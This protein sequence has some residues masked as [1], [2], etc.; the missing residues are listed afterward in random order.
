MQILTL[1]IDWEITIFKVLG[2]MGLF[3]YGMDLLGKSLKRLA[4]SKLKII[5]EKTTNTPLKGIL[6]GILITGLLQ[7]SS[8]VSV[9]VIGLVRAGLMTLPQ[10]IGVI[11]GANI[12]T[13]IT[14]VLIG[15]DIGK[16]ALII[17]FV[18][19]ALVFFI[20]KK[21]IQE[22]GKAILGFGLLF[23]GLETMGDS[24]KTLIELPVI[25]NLFA[26]VGEYPILGLFTGLGVTA[27]IQSSSATVGLLQQLY[28]TGGVPLIGGVAII[29]GCNI[30]TT[31][32]AVIA[33]IGAPVAAKRTAAIHI[34][35]NTI[36]AI[37]FMIFLT[38]FTGLIQWLAE[39]IYGADWATN[40]MTISLAHVLFNVGNV[41][42]MYWF[43]KQ[44]TWLV[45]KAIP[46]RGEIQVD[47]VI[48]DN[49]LVK[50]SPVLAL[51]NAK[52]AITNMGNVCKAMFE[53]TF[54]YSFERN[55][56]NLEMGRQCEELLDTIDSKV[57]NYLVKIGACEIDEPQIQE[58]AKDIDTISDLERIGDHLDNLLDFFEER[59]EQK[60][61]LHPEAKAELTELYDTLRK[62]LYE[63]MTAYQDQNKLIATEVNVREEVIDRL[64]KRNRKNHI[65]RINDQT[66]SETEAG[67]YV[68]ILSNM[69]RIGDHCNNI[70]LNVLSEF[71]THDETFITKKDR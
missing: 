65:G 71:Y 26:S 15:L 8:A 42:L 6:V 47:E 39:L 62:T 32:T 4:G 12:G 46:S 22:L 30:G 3:L 43:I 23:F 48:L 60:M 14:S 50:E 13:T 51:A 31:V 33:S 70:V 10:A 41:F 59:H 34:L 29:F 55:D 27:I 9:L 63:S 21:K 57:H 61:E 37:I 45:I 19:S 36:G 7:S 1:A 52:L 53:Y 58:L 5:L 25:Q 64:V 44:M 38:P 40:R 69:E 24:L 68:D 28:A 56:K 2:G 16:Y 20:Q 49:A 35:F 66:C 18:G 54:D 67:Y 11:F 17:V